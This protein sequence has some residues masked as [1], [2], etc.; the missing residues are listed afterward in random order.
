M[1]FWKLLA[2]K[3]PRYWDVFEAGTRCW[4][5]G[6]VGQAGV[7]RQHPSGKGRGSLACR[8]CTQPIK[9]QKH[10][11]NNLILAFHQD[12]SRAQQ[13]AK[14]QRQ[15]WADGPH[16][17]RRPRTSRPCRSPRPLSWIFRSPH[18]LWLV[19]LLPGSV[20]YKVLPSLLPTQVG[21]APGISIRVVFWIS[22]I[23]HLCQS[24]F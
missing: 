15:L 2:S 6:D 22:C 11:M 14:L 12:T 17:P 7:P 8:K 24:H 13:C 5:V 19:H 16:A 3:I 4:G 23:S 18:F 21:K 1:K 10:V 20:C 9:T